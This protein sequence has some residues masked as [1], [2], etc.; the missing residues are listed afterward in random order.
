MVP[1]LVQ[2]LCPTSSVC[3]RPLNNKKKYSPYFIGER[4]SGL[5]I[6][7]TIGIDDAPQSGIVLMECG[8][9]LLKEIR[10]GRGR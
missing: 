3:E 9:K 10:D 7:W 8:K 4:N 2:H 5:D 6:D 1:S